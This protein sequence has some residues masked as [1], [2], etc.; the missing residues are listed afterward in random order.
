[1]TGP[2][3]PALPVDPLTAERVRLTW[4]MRY[5]GKKLREI[6]A[7]LGVAKSTV[8]GYLHDPDGARHRRRKD[9]YRKP[10]PECGAL[11]D[12]GYKSKSPPRCRA[13]H[14]KAQFIWTEEA[15]IAA[16]QRFASRY[17]SPPSASDFNPAMAQA[18]G[19]KDHAERFY[20]DGDYPCARSVA[21]RFGSWSAGIAAAGFAPRPQ[22]GG[23]RYA[24]DQPGA[25]KRA[26]ALYASGLSLLKVADALGVSQGFVFR[27]VHA[28]GI[29]RGRTEA[30]ALR[31]TR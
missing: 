29:S 12:S 28:A 2:E 10:C 27:H 16:I 15:I 30:A 8:A 1:M 22:G 4:S 5:E 17:G 3:P 11:M 25:V 20:R 23:R 6:A 9:S 7:V 19:Q 13:C 31:R 18:I 14:N 24:G 26:V 21:V